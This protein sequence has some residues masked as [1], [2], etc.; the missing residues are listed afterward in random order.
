MNN[1][2]YIMG[3]GATQA[4]ATHAGAVIN[5]LMNSNAALGTGISE[6]VLNAASKDG[7]L[8]RN[9]LGIEEDSDTDIEK[10]ITLLA[11]T[12]TK[13][14]LIYTEELRKSY[15]KEIING[16]E[17]AR[18]LEEPELAIALLQ[19]HKNEKFTEMEKLLGIISLNHDDL[20]Q[21]ASQKVYSCINLGFDFISDYFDSG[22]PS[23]EPFLIQ[24]HGSFSWRRR[25]KKLIDVKRIKA[26]G[27]YDS[28][29]TWIPPSIL[30]ETKDYPFNKLTGLAY[31]LLV[32]CDILRIVGCSLSQNDWNLISLIFNAQNA[33]Y[34]DSKSCFDIELIMEIDADSFKKENSYLKNVIPIGQLTDGDFSGYQV[35][36]EERQRP[37]ELDNPF[38]FWLK[39]K[40]SFHISQGEFDIGSAGNQ[41]RKIIGI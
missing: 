37:S 17:E 8:I 36:G 33:Q 19:M 15:Y 27:R 5:L 31:E 32:D 16:I 1:I 10:L 12:G 41:L 35:P 22:Y 30:K 20:F 24:L 40:V 13:Q 3:A 11:A 23:Q 14:N 6:K 34:I 9:I 21:E 28:S 18:I 2:V 38:E 7:Q 25:K 4:E 26:E 39:E 29:M